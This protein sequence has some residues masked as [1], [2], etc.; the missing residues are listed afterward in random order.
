F[1]GTPFDCVFVLPFLQVTHPLSQ[2]RSFAFD[3]QHR[4]SA[5]AERRHRR[6]PRSPSSSKKWRRGRDSPAVK[7]RTTEPAVGYLIIC[8]AEQHAAGMP[9]AEDNTP[10]SSCSPYE[11][12]L[13]GQ[14]GQTE[15]SRPQ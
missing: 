13:L 3:T 11:I 2:T 8:C 1:S 4:T 9:E 15:D 7:H 6:C 5:S 12:T 10:L 14:I